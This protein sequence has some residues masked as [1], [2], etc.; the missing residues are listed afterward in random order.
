MDGTSDGADVGDEL[1]LGTSLGFD[2]GRPDS[3]GASEGCKLG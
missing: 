2:V 3:D 1:L